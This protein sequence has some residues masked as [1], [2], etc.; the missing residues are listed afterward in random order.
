VLEVVEKLQL[1]INA[2][3]LKVAVPT[4]HVNCVK[5][6]DPMPRE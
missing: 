3:T 4:P 1:S 6:A 5:Y 2:P